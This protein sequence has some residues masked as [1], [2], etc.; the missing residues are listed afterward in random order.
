MWGGR[1]PTFRSGARS[2]V[3]TPHALTAAAAVHRATTLLRR[4]A[5]LGSPPQSPHVGRPPPHIPIWSSVWCPNPARPDRGR[6]R[7]PRDDSPS[8]PRASR[9]TTSIPTCGE[10]ASPHSDLELGLVSQPRTP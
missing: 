5:R 9:I 4:L 3:P 10:A 6:R 7:S 1:L 8:P 2:G